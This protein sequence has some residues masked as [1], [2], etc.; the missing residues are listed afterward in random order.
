MQRTWY[1]K[2]QIWFILQ[3]AKI[4]WKEKKLLSP[5]DDIKIKEKFVSDYY[6]IA[7]R[8]SNYLTT[9]FITL[10]NFLLTGKWGFYSHVLM[11]LEDEVKDDDDFRFIEATGKGV[12]YST[13]IDVFG[14]VDAVAL[15]KP[16]NITLEEWTKALDKAKTYLGRPYDNLFDLKSDLEINCVELIRLALEG[17]DNYSQNFAEFEKL[18]AAKGKITPDMF[19]NCS[20]FEVVF[21]IRR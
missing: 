6:I 13:F 12:H 9:F 7:T 14:T 5:E 16:K 17:T 8:K 11:N 4:K 15:I 20:D 10:G 1:Q 21:S 19:V 2:I 3:L 18:V